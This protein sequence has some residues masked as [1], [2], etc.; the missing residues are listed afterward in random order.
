MEETMQILPAKLTLDDVDLPHYA[1]ADSEHLI[2]FVDEETGA[3]LVQDE[4]EG[5]RCFQAG[6]FASLQDAAD[7]ITEEVTRGTWI[8][9][10]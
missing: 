9:R 7:Y 3:I 10:A 5:T 1:H 2:V 8:E 4:R 6:P